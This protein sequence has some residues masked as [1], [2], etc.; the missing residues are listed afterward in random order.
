VWLVF[1]LVRELHREYAR[2]GADVIQAFTFFASDGHM[3]VG[4]KIYD[5]R[6]E[7]LWPVDPL[8]DQEGEEM[9]WPVDP[10]H[11]QE[12]EEMLWPVDPLL[13]QL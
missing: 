8:L 6:E 4:G 11:D 12:G 7:M 13:D 10:L 2:A 3:N 9:L 5:V 1:I